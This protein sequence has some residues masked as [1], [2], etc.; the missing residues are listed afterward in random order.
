MYREF[1][2]S[3]FSGNFGTMK[4]NDEEQRQQ[5]IEITDLSLKTL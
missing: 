2:E 3:T 1:E 5:K 4:F